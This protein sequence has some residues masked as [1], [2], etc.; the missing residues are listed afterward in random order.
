[1]IW[2]QDKFMLVPEPQAQETRHDFTLFHGENVGRHFRHMTLFRGDHFL[3]ERPR[4]KP[5]N[6]FLGRHDILIPVW[7]QISCCIEHRGMLLENGSLLSQDKI[8]NTYNAR[9]VRILEASP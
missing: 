1:M 4:K 3:R 7:K 6:G 5:Q 8:C 9:V 2:S